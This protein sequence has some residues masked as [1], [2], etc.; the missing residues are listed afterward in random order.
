MNGV[1][2]VTVIEHYIYAFAQYFCI[3]ISG[4][5]FQVNNL[6]KKKKKTGVSIIIP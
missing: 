2:I 5:R 3:I 6:G 1:I 4:F